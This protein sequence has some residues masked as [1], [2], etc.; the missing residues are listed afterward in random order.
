MNPAPLF[1]VLLSLLILVNLFMLGSSRIG[2]LIRAIGGQS[3]LV[4]AAAAALAHA[5]CAWHDWLLLACTLAVKGGILPYMMR[6]ALTR[7]HIRRDVEPLIGYALSLLVGLAVLGLSL[8]AVRC[9]P[10]P[11][12][13]AATALAAA[14]FTVACGFVLIAGRTK[15]I[16]QTIGYLTL[17]NGIYLL[18]FALAIENPLVVEVGI[19]LDVLVGIFVM[20]IITLQINREFDHIDI[21]KLQ[22][23][24]G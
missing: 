11:P 7:A 23:L 21:K 6:R 5:H 24:K 13:A 2:A 8:A 12:G 3:I 17:E 9:L 14:F 16:T 22:R 20:G 19:L 1:E 18:G 4:C 10:L 15:A